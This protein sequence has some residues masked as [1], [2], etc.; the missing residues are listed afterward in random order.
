MPRLLF[1]DMVSR[2]TFFLIATIFDLYFRDG[3]MLWLSPNF[4]VGFALVTAALSWWW[5]RTRQPDLFMLATLLAAGAAVLLSALAEAEL[6]FSAGSMATFLLWGLLVTGVTAGLAKILLH[7]QRS[8]M[9]SPR[10][11]AETVAFFLQSLPA[12]L[13][14]T[15]GKRCGR[16]CRRADFVPLNQ[17]LS[18]ALGRLGAAT[19]P[20]VCQG[21]ACLWR[22][23]GGG[24]LYRLFW[25]FAF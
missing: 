4:V 25:I 22:M 6:F 19:L 16:T 11:E 8:M 2:T 14:G 10:Q 18:D 20:L 17:S 5:Y 7:L 15:T 24:F 3:Q 9:T 13:P 12:P 1:F 23:D 21:H